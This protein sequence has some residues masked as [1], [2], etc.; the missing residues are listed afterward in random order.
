VFKKHPILMTLLI[1]FIVI[2]TLNGGWFIYWEGGF[3]GRVINAVNKKPIEGAVV[4]AVYRVMGIYLIDG[5]T[6]DVDIEYT[7]TDSNGEYHIPWNLYF[8]HWPLSLSREPTEISVIKP[9][10]LN[11]LEGHGFT[12][13]PIKDTHTTTTRD[14]K[15]EVRDLEGIVYLQSKEMITRWQGGHKK[16][17]S[18]QVPFFPLKNP[19]ER[20]RNLDRRLNFYIFNAES[21]YRGR[22]WKPFKTYSVIGLSLG[23][24]A[25]SKRRFYDEFYGVDREY[26]K[27][28]SEAIKEEDRL[29]NRDKR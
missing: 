9:G 2:V 6:I 28:I 15:K 4:V 26:Q 8:Y 24:L 25:F 10:Y 22:G 1:T 23:N 17:D 5:G 3:R 12:L 21:I 11:V 7:L 19:S 20:L 27:L 16:F 14:G 13:H 18:E 29:F